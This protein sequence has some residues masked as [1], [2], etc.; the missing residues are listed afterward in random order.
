MFPVFLSIYLMTKRD[1]IF[2]G[3]IYGTSNY[4]LFNYW[5]AEFSPVA[6]SVVPIIQGLY[7]ILL[8]IILRLIVEKER[9]RPYLAMSLLWLVY[10]IFRGENFIGYNYGTLAHTFYKTHHF[11]GIIDITGTYFLSFLIVFPASLAAAVSI[12]RVAIKKAILPGIIYIGLI[13]FAIIYTELS[14]VDYSKSRKVR[15]SLIQHNL[16][17]WLKGSTKLYKEALDNL[18]ELSKEGEKEG[19][20]LIIWAESAF[21][22]AIEWH[23][24]YRVNKGRLELVNEMEEYFRSSGADFLVGSNETIGEPKKDKIRYNPVYHY[25]GENIINKYRKVRLVPFTE[26]FPN[27]KLLPWL[28][29]YTL[30]LGASQLEH[31]ESYINFTFDDFTGTPLIC[32]EDTFSEA[33][34]IGTLNGSSL[35]INMTNDAWSKEEA[36]SRQ[37]LSAAVFRTIENRRTMVRAGTG[38]YTAVIDPNGR[39]LLELPLLVKDQLTSDVPLYNRKTTVYTRYGHII[40]RS[41]LL[42][43]SIYLFFILIRSTLSLLLLKKK[44]VLN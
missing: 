1:A 8:F 10:E 14:K 16:D 5:L 18:I 38:G 32:Y 15:V 13:L 17:C 25:R 34:R 44:E 29:N 4:L 21:V 35:L 20:R 19:S 12:G 42:G 33:S 43:A 3:F 22:P 23:K 11:T 36:A 24:E 41:Y 31:G 2:Y 40:E 28:Y 30:K 7:S 6:F 27:P 39:I 26:Y 37:H 9:T